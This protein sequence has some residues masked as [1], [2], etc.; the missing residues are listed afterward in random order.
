MAAEQ[1]MQP[2]VS[3]Q[4][5]A[6][7]EQNVK[8]AIKTE[9]EQQFGAVA[10]ESPE[11]EGNIRECL[12]RWPGQPVQPEPGERLLRQWEDQWQGFLKT[13]ESP[14]S[15]EWERPGLPDAS[16]PWGDAQ[17]FLA[18]F[19]QVAEA[20]LWPKEEWAAR[21]RPAL[22]GEAGQAFVRLEARDREDYGKVKAALLRREALRRE[23]TRQHFRS[24]GYREAEGPRAVHGRLR[25]LCRG[26]LKVEKHTKEQILEELVLEQFLAV[27]PP[28]VQTW[29]RGHGPET[30]A[31]A[32]ALAEGFLGRP[33]KSEGLEQHVLVEGLHLSEAEQASLDCEQDRVDYEAGEGVSTSVGEDLLS[34]NAR[35]Q[36]ESADEGAVES[37]EEEVSQNGDPEEPSQYWQESG[38]PQRRS[39]VEKGGNAIHCEGSESLGRTSSL[40]GIHTMN[41]EVHEKVGNDNFPNHSEII[42]LQATHNASLPYKCLD[43]GKSL[44]C[45]TNLTRHRRIHTGE[46]PY[47]CIECGRCFR[48]S[49]DLTNHQRIHTGDKP[50]KCF[51]CG[52]CFRQS[53]GL[54]NHQRIHTGEKPYKC[55]DCGKCFRQSSGL[56]NHQ[57]IHTGEKPYKCL[58]CGKCFHQSSGL[59]YHQRIHRGEKLYKCLECGKYFH[60]RLSLTN[61]QRIHTEEKPYQC[62]VC[63]K[64]FLEKSEIRR[65]SIVH[66]REMGTRP[67]T[68]SECGK[69]FRW[70]SKL[71]T[72]QKTH[73]RAKPFG[74]A[75][76]GKSYN[77]HMRLVQHQRVHTA[78]NPYTC[79]SCGK[80][81]CDSRGLTRHQKIH[82]GGKPYSCTDCGKSFKQKSN[83]RSH[84]K[85]HTGVKT[86]LCV[87]CGKNF[88]SRSEL[89]RHYVI[90]VE[91]KSDKSL[92]GGDP[93]VP[94]QEK[95]DGEQPVRKE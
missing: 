84:Q 67:Y 70:N 16:A 89:Q 45:S 32:V 33:C 37:P 57:R 20:C 81:F 27:L 87:D 60:H 17:A 75:V 69:G 26:W 72:H 90:H 7:T 77:S 31:Q 86:F 59:T 34:V 53:W 61:H 64:S 91:D 74:C 79:S 11:D 4:L 24:F 94:A 23:K 47:K 93:E 46:K 43:C 73:M 18:S 5:P 21:L 8:H 78:S 38:Q 85:T 54:R 36:P 76:C 12:S 82:T 48:Q 35:D 42:Q 83:L 19:E 25:E 39:P 44:S 71:I 50:Y 3:S 30:G 62:L 29:V 14:S 68:C 65:H 41:Q 22:R 13:V 88:R 2:L 95:M 63:G 6:A 15:S 55:F 92:G 52:K 9:E 40:Q 10:A 49:W 56:M 28:E 66:Q 80:S 58:D 1:E 51:D